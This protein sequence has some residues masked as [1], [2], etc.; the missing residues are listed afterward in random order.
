MPGGFS[1]AH[2]RSAIE[3]NKLANGAKRAKNEQATELAARISQL[4]AENAVLK[5]QHAA[6]VATLKTQQAAEVAAL[7]AQNATQQSKIVAHTGMFAAQVHI[8]A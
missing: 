8:P 1:S 4:E 5:A 6:E 7:K 3:K 2:K